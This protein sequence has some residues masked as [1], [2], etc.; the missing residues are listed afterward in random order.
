V[1]PILSFRRASPCLPCGPTPGLASR[2]APSTLVAYVPGA[3]NEFGTAQREARWS[4]SPVLASRRASPCLPPGP[5]SGL[6]SEQAPYSLGAGA[7]G[8]SRGGSPRLRSRRFHQVDSPRATLL[9]ASPCAPPEARPGDGDSPGQALCLPHTRGPSVVAYARRGVRSPVRWAMSALGGRCRNAG[10]VSLRWSQCC[11]C[12]SCTRRVVG[13]HHV[14]CMQQPNPAL[15]RTRREASS[16]LAGIVPARRLALALGCT[17][18]WW[19]CEC[20]WC[21]RSCPLPGRSA[22]ASRA[23][24]APS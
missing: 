17:H 10:W 20:A 4:A 6:A 15:K 5:A 23:V 16:C 1:S 3:G 13:K 22:S 11:G 12:R 8:C 2:Q 14:L 24:V 18:T 19:Q 9:C 21:R 7:A